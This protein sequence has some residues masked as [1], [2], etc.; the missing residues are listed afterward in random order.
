[1]GFIAAMT[2]PFELKYRGKK[3]AHGEVVKILLRHFKILLDDPSLLYVA[4]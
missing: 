1:M 4:V 3:H 2:L